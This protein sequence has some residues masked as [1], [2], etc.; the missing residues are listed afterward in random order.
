M[1]RCATSF[2]SICCLKSQQEAGS[3]V[4][5]GVGRAKCSCGVVPSAAGSHGCGWSANERRGPCSLRHRQLRRRSGRSPL[6]YRRVVFPVRPRLS[7]ARCGVAANAKRQ[8]QSHPHSR[9]RPET[10]RQVSADLRAPHAASGSLWVVGGAAPRQARPWGT[11]TTA[12]PRRGRLHFPLPLSPA[13]SAG[14]SRRLLEGARRVRGRTRTTPPIAGSDTHSDGS[15]AWVAG[16]TI[17]A[18]PSHKA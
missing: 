10:R 17:A 8:R 9:P 2:G 16:R 18:S 7:A 6:P 1:L 3:C 13:P 4:G 5:G 12:P 15:S 14:L 11:F